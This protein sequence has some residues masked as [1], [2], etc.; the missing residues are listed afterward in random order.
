MYG[1][2]TGTVETERTSSSEGTRIE[3]LVA[4][5]L[6]SYRSEHTRAAYGADLAAFRAWCAGEGRLPLQASMHDVARYFAACEAT[7]V[8]G[9]TLA[10]RMSSLDS[11]FRFACDSAATRENPAAAVDRPPLAV[12]SPTARLGGAEAAALLRASDRLGPKPAALVRLLMLDGLKLGEV[13]AADAADY[14]RGGGELLVTRRGRGAPVAL[15]PPTARRL[16]RYLG[17]RRRGPLLTSD[18]PGRE[19]AR[20]TRFGADYIL[21]RVG[22]AARLP[23]TVS[24]NAL[25]RRYVA[26]AAS[27]GTPVDEIRDRLG[28]RDS[29][30]VARYLDPEPEARGA[31][32]TRPTRR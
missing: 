14:D 1:R 16:D 5:W 25:R 19:L 17:R 12:G 10:R 13:L 15:Q 24:A 2:D 20:L 31:P 3:L 18:T 26:A 21:K 23:T 11:F 22:S 27:A 30:T 28:R 7:G 4:A 9:S 6:D 8:S 32:T 29:R